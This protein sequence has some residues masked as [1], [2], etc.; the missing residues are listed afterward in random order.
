MRRF[1]CDFETTTDLKDCRVWAYA[2][3]EIG[4][5]DNFSYGNSLDAFMEWCANT[6]ENFTCYFHN[7]KFDGAFIVD[8]LLKNDFEYIADKK[9]RRD[10]TFTTLITD[11]GQWYQLEIWFK[12]KGH[13]VNKVTILDSLKILNFSV[14]FIASKKGFNLPQQKLELDY[15]AKR[16]IGHE[17]TQHEIDYI[18]NDVWIMAEALDIMFNQNLKKMTIAGDALSSFKDM[19]PNFKKLFPTL[20]EEMDEDIRASYKGGFTYVSD[21]YAGKELGAGVTLDVNS[22][23]PSRMKFEQLPIGMPETFSGKYQ[24]DRLY[25]LYIQKLECIFKIKPDKIPSIQIKHHLSFIQ[26][27]YLKSSNGEIV[28]LMLTNPD[29]ELFFEQYDVEVISWCGG[30]KFRHMKGVFDEYIDH[31]TESKIQAKKDG[32]QAL[33]LISK[34]MLNS[35]Y[36]KF[37][38]GIKGKKKIP[39]LVNGK[40]QFVT[41]QEEKKKGVYLPVAS[42]ITA[43]A[44]K[45]TIETSQ[46]IREWSEKHKGFDAY[47]YSDTDSIHA[48]L[49]KND[50]AILCDIIDIDDFR[51]GAWKHESSFT[52]AKFIRQKCYIEQDA[53]DGEIH[54]TI[55][56][57][58]KKLGHLVNFD[59][60]KIGF[61]TEGLSDEEIGKAGRK[62]RY[63]H[64]K[65]G[66][67]LVDTDFT[68]K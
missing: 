46:M 3:C 14:D 25:P 63:K 18:H 13:K 24:Y 35:L 17:L 21:K 48:L 60:F 11:M 38:T 28:S 51:L 20:P 64:V 62:L 29:L 31:W 7:L 67:V 23:Y 36:G 30:Y 54:A 42:F 68:L 57:F 32:N 37:G 50:L 47:C 53:E 45:Y 61:T 15:R 12:V 41:G 16:E 43:Y 2:C 22:L 55:A 10:N 65:G 56:G 33:Y 4:N 6:K 40:T 52:R 9:E 66:V 8:W 58:P 1:C 26:N 34:L 27:E 44:R 5:S 39:V 19:C 49:N 59:N